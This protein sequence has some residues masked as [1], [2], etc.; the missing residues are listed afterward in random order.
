MAYRRWYDSDAFS[1]T[2]T[3]SLTLKA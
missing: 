3:V 1:I 2:L